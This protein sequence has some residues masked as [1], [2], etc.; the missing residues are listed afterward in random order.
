MY[1]EPVRPPPISRPGLGHADHEALPQPAGL[2]GCPVLLVNHTPVV[3]LALLDYGLIV[4]GP[5]KERFAS[6]ACEGPEMEACCR[7][8]AYPAELVLHGVKRAV[9]L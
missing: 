7:L 9:K 5:A 4:A 1:L 2:A 8:L 3:V 6:L